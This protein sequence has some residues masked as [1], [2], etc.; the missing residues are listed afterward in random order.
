[1]KDKHLITKGSQSKEKT[2][3]AKHIKLKSKPAKK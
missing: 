3:E 1:M 2:K